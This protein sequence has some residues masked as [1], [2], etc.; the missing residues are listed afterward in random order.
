MVL[1][2][3]GY[4]QPLRAMIDRIVEGGFGHHKITE[5][6]TFVETAD[7]VWD[8]LSSAP[9]PDILVLASHL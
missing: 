5:L 9:K 2:V 6:L 8:A 1:D 7:Q 4:W 3:N